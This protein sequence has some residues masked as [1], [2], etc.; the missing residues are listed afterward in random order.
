MVG[1]GVMVTV[2]EGFN[3]GA[4]VIVETGGEVGVDGRGVSVGAPNVKS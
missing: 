2:G 3:V 1:E 4:E